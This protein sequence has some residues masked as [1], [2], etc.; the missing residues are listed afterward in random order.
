MTKMLQGDQEMM[1]VCE[2]AGVSAKR[3]AVALEGLAIRL[4]F[5]RC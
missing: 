1:T 3:F 5:A 2:G 4:K